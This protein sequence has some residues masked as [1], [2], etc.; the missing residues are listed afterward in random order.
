[1]TELVAKY[2]NEC[3]HITILARQAVKGDTGFQE[4][5]LERFNRKSG[6]SGG[7]SPTASCIT[8]LLPAAKPLKAPL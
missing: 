8:R 3:C 6:R 1:M 5:R 7:A 2:R 4:S